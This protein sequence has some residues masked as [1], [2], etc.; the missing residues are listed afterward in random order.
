MGF[1]DKIFD[2]QFES[3][4]YEHLSNFTFDLDPSWKDQRSEEEKIV[5][6]SVA[7]DIHSSIQSSRF[8]RFNE[9][10]EFGGHSKLK[11]L[12]INEVYGYITDELLAKYSHI[13]LFSE[14]CTYF[15]INP[16]VFYSSLSN[17]YKEALIEELDQRTG[18]LSRRKIKKLF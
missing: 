1:N 17:G 2:N 10:D 6:E 11:K 15:D 14:L 3:T 13:D 9:I 4:E 8:N 7:R 16:S 5:Q 12:D 18:V